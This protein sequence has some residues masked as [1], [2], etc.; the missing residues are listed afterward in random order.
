MT[1]RNDKIIH[2]ANAYISDINNPLLILEE[3]I[4][5]KRVFI[6]PI[7]GTILAALTAIA[8]V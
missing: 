3:N 4:T 1:A 2:R 8:G 6:P 5:R 7:I